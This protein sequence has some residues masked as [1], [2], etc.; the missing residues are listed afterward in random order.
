M[1]SSLTLLYTYIEY[2]LVHVNCYYLNTTMHTIIPLR[3]I[4]F[5]KRHG[6]CCE[7]L[8]QHSKRADFAHT[9]GWMPDF[10]LTQQLRFHCGFWK[11]TWA[12]PHRGRWRNNHTRTQGWRLRCGAKHNNNPCAGQRLYAALLSMNLQCWIQGFP[13]SWPMKPLSS[14][15]LPSVNLKR[16]IQCKVGMNRAQSSNNWTKQYLYWITSLTDCHDSIKESMILFQFPKHQKYLHWCIFHSSHCHNNMTKSLQK[17]EVGNNS[18]V[19]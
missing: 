6:K 11:S 14:T 10:A 19:I 3:I 9:D 4:S 12:S 15:A 2:R 5:L 8:P 13:W 7:F 18:P 16:I 1:N 17:L